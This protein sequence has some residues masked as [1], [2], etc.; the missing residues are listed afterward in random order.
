V[1][2]DPRDRYAN[3]VGCADAAR[4]HGDLEMDLIR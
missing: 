4:L 1:H 3:S 2:A